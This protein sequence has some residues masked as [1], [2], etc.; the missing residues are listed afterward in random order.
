MREQNLRFR[1]RADRSAGP[2]I[3]F[4]E[5]P[6]SLTQ[7]TSESGSDGQ[8]WLKPLKE[9][10]PTNSSGVNVEQVDKLL[11]HVAVHGHAVVVGEVVE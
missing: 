5:S 8:C 10:E 1:G 2:V 11:R 3:L 7:A 9:G 6:I 4:C